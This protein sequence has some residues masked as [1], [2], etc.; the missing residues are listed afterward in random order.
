MLIL[1]ILAVPFWLLFALLSAFVLFLSCIA[2][3]V[4]LVAYVILVLLAL[5]LF[6]AGQTVG[7]I[8]FVVMAFLVSPFGLPAIAD[9]LAD[10][11]CSIKEALHRFVTG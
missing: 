5:L 8:V 10:G 6:V 7:G 4:C 3:A 11:L 2:S 9:R 1:R